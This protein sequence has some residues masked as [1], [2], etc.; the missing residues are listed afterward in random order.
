M[1][2]EQEIRQDLHDL[3]QQKSVG[4]AVENHYLTAIK[5]VQALDEE[6]VKREREKLRE[7]IK[8]VNSKWPAFLEA[9]PQTAKHFH[10]HEKAVKAEFNKTYDLPKLK[11]RLKWLNYLLD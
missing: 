5:T 4:K 8:V 1:K 11:T 9:R 6:Q 3:K 10:V 7:Q 2:T